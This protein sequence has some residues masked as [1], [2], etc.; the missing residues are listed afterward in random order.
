MTATY[1]LQ[2]RP[3]FG[4]A[5]AEAIL[6]YL[7]RLGVS[8]L[9]LSPITEAR[10]GSTH[11]YDVVDHN[12]ISEALG[13]REGFDRLAAACAARGLGIVLDW[14]PNH[15]GVGPG[16]VYWQDMLAYGPHS[17]TARFFDV[18]WHPLKRNLHDKV[19]LP[20]LGAP[21][22]EALDAG[23]IGLS[24][25]DG[26][27]YATY[28]DS[29]FALS[30]STYAALL[31]A[32]LP[33][34][35]R[36]DAYFDLK[37]LAEAYR[38]VEP[39][40]REKAEALRR[41][42]L[43][44]A[45]RADVA[46]GL[47]DVT[48]DALHDLLDRQLWRLASWKTAGHDI[49]YRRFFD[50]NGLV[51]LRMEDPDVFWDA[52]QL[53]GE[54]L[55][56]DGVHGVR[57]DHVDGLFD[58]HGYL[59]HLRELGAQHVWVE[60][61][62]AP[63]EPLPPEWPTEGTTGYEF[64]NAVVHLVLREDGLEALDAVWRRAVP[65]APS[66]DETVHASKALVMETSLPGELARLATGLNRISESDYHTRDFTLGALREALEEI[67][68]AFDRYRTYLPY[69]AED[70]RA[71]VR[72]AIIRAKMQTPATE[73]S[74][75]DF[76]GRVVLG[77][78]EA[79]EA[80]AEPVRQWVGRFQQYTAPVAAKG[81]EDTAFYRYARLLALNEVGGEP[82][83][84]ALAPKG[85]HADAAA[86]A[87][88]YPHNLLATATH[89]HKRGE[90]TRLRLAALTEIPDTWAAA[91]DALDIATR[92]FCGD[93]GPSPLDR[94]VVYQTLAALWTPP[95]AADAAAYRAD[96][97]DRLWDYVQ[98]ATREAKLA[99]NWLNPD[100]AYEA[101]LEAFVRA[102]VADDGVAEALAP[103]AEQ[104][105]ALGL[106]STFT[107]T[108]L[109]LTSPGVPDLY[110]GTE[111][112]DLS[113]VDPDNRRPVDYDLRQQTLDALAAH[114]DAPDADAVRAM[115][116]GGDA[117]AKPYL[118]ARLLQ[119]RR[120][121]PEVFEGGYRPLPIE[122]DGADEWLA[123]ARTDADGPALVTVVPRFATSAPGAT[124]ELPGS[125]PWLEWLSGEE[126][127]GSRTVAVGDLPLPW[128]VLVRP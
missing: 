121:R 24:Y 116:E 71:V 125:G 22:G 84:G 85:F 38:G 26:R 41:R 60:K 101:D 86:R 117:Q 83:H 25:D 78:T 57:I 29:R 34:H 56:Q 59:E 1:R 118:V 48:G 55:A 122:G 52:H 103:V 62:L 77:E 120:E 123:F 93:R 2:L 30:P 12:R 13:G 42:L 63:D 14:V 36:E 108:V 46:A 9:Y 126:V 4:F 74:V 51:A 94:Y 81:V 75:Y 8:H 65:A 45:E 99:T 70:A 6:P 15:A 73:H 27:F 68:A 69:D 124:V 104:V 114:L 66:W 111:T 82:A 37:D 112:L 127:G 3:E 109:K 107:Q 58:P 102:A 128:S 106:R 16:N 33:A 80:L 43:A 17:P 54:L 90:D 32:A 20:F 88:R 105:A 21:Y 7:D 87:E 40:E 53:L 31:D 95:P 35:E 119:L 11:G 76:I 5:E 18:D 67:V 92:G 28:Y 96:L 19:L 89:D 50:I 49:N 115:L 64:M 97:A 47:A 113:L 10:A 61:I 100:E 91:V 98:K 72:R 44:L 110:Q 23:E 79:P 39:H